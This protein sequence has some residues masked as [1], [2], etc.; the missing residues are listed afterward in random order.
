MT[1]KP[2]LVQI[3]LSLNAG[4][5]ER[6]VVDMSKLLA[7]RAN[8][9]VLCLDE[10]GEWASQLSEVGITVSTLGRKPGFD[11]SLVKKVRAYLRKLDKPVVHC[12][13]YTPFV[14]GAL[15]SLLSGPS[16]LIYT[17]HGR[18]DDGKPSKKRW[19]ANQVLARLPGHFFAVS[20]DLRSHLA[21][22]GFSRM[23]VNHNGIDVRAVPSAAERTRVR[24]TLGIVSDEFVVGTVA[25]LHPV[26]NLG[27][28]IRAL[29]ECDSQSR[30]V[31]VGDG[32]ERGR[33]EHEARDLGVFQ[34]VCFSAIA[35]MRGMSSQPSMST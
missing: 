35:T 2:D 4:G 6:L 28:L 13:H 19:L 9:H 5:T 34:R 30:L 15:A 26:K 10:A 8:V 7:S 27:T 14:Y 22:E 32:E 18:Y 25:R 3:V 1:S 21:G 29:G 33:L 23:Q 11:V 24:E 20:H 16:R 12:H 17:E 31:V